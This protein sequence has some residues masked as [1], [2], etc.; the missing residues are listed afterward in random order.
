MEPSFFC[1]GNTK[2]PMIIAMVCL[3]NNLIFN[4]IFYKIFQ[5]GY[6]GI[7]LSSVISSY[8]NLT[9]L[10]SLLIKK[11]YF[12]FA[13]GFL[14]K[15]LRIIIPAILMAIS[16]NIIS[17]YFGPDNNLSQIIKLTIMI[18]AGFAIYVL[19]SIF[20]GSFRIFLSTNLFKRKKNKI[21]IYE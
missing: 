16:L 18:S 13:K 20:S 5:F 6:I 19:A 12:H 15:L 3:V 7:V 2:T 17:D 11:R 10:I 4:L 14:I 8:L 21:K 1:R 9:L